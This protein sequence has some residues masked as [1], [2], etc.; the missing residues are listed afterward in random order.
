MS[1]SESDTEKT[2]EKAPTDNPV[3]T[4]S[5][6]TGKIEVK[7]YIFPPEEEVRIAEWLEGYPL[8]WDT[9]N[10]RHANKTQVDKVREEG[11]AT[12]QCPG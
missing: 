12:F 3:S 11:A 1:Q 2:K 4:E 10:P 7:S 8:L 9:K 6:S 5:V